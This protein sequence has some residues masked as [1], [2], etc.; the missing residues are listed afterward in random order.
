MKASGTITMEDRTWDFL[1]YEE[2]Q[3]YVVYKSYKKEKRVVLRT[4][5]VFS[6]WADAF[7]WAVD[8]CSLPY[9]RGE[10]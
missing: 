10:S 7:A 6:S 9:K 8:R 3:A 2:G 5:S 4:S 1:A